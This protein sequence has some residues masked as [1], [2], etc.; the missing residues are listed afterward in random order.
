[1]REKQGIPSTMRKTALAAALAAVC[2]QA[3][4]TLVADGKFDATEGYQLGITFGINDTHG[5]TNYGKLY[6]GQDAGGQYLY[7]QMPLGYVDNVYGAPANDTGT[8]WFSGHSFLDLLQGD[9]QGITWKAAN[10]T[11]THVT[12]DYLAD[13][14]SAG[15][16]ACS[17]SGYKSSGIGA[18]GTGGAGTSGWQSVSYD[19]GSGSGS[20]LKQVATSLEYNLNTV[21]GGTGANTD[22]PL[23]N[24]NWIKD[25]GYELQF[26]AGTFNAQD[27][28]DKAKA[29]GL[30]SLD[31]PGVAP[32]KKTFKD[33]TT[34]SCTFGC[35]GTAPEPS[36]NW[37]LALGAAALLWFARRR[38]VPAA[39]GRLLPR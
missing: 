28:V 21:I 27:W 29:P 37:L 32:S 13:C 7:I 4:A 33:Y 10:N 22:S 17:P 23:A 6:F 1:M 34:P 25:V 9:S 5:T 11:T 39:L 35:N 19:N 18:S 20:A 2:T 8:G 36:T 24:P 38:Q 15:N 12:L 26:A 31:A 30:I 16:G 14:G 3:G